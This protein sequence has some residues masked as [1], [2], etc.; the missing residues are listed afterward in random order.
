MFLQR[1]AAASL[2]KSLACTNA[3]S[4]RSVLPPPSNHRNWRNLTWGVPDPASPQ[5]CHC[6]RNPRPPSSDN[7]SCR[8]RKSCL[9]DDADP[10]I[11]K[12]RRGWPTEGNTQSTCRDLDAPTYIPRGLDL[13]LD[14]RRGYHRLRRPGL[15]AGMAPIGTGGI[16]GSHHGQRPPR[17]GEVVIAPIA[18]A[19]AI[20]MWI[21]KA[22]AGT[23]A[24]VV[25][26]RAMRLRSTTAWATET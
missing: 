22:K 15:E 5:T 4:L 12:G 7:R 24:R 14:L 11:S 21:E 25:G 20:G 26:M 10:G 23:R 13:D 17:R 6:R 9:P 3:F 19:G 2:L 8:M 16:G 1:A 18:E